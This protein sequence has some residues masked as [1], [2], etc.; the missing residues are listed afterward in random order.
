MFSNRIQ[1][2]H[3]LRVRAAAELELRR[4][5]FNQISALEGK[6][7][8]EAERERRIYYQ[9]HPIDWI[10]D[11]L[12]IRREMIDWELLPQY[13]RH[14]WDG[15]PNPFKV[16]FDSLVKKK[17]VAIEGATGTSKTFYAACAKLWFLENFEDSMV[18]TTAPKK[19]QLELHIWK[20]TSRLYPRFGRGKLM[21]LELRMAPDL[22]GDQGWKAIGFVAGVKAEEVGQSAR[23]AQGFHG[24]DML[25]IVEETPGVAEAVLTALEN[26]SVAPNNLILALGNPD[27]QL[28]ALHKFSQ[29]K[30]VVPITISAF[31]HP[32]VVL[33]D[34]TYMP[35][36]QTEEGLINMLDRL[37]S[38][39]NPMY[40]S[41]ARGISPKQAK[42]ALIR[43]EWILKAVER[44]RKF[45]DE[46]GNIKPESIV[47]MRALGVDVANSEDGDRGAIAR[48]K[49]SVLLEVEEFPCPNANRLGEEVDN[50]IKSLTIAPSYV[51][52]DGIGVGA[53]AVNELKRL[54]S[55][56]LDI[57]SAESP[58]DLYGR[59]EEGKES[60][61]KLV[62]TFDNLRSQ[63]WWQLR[64]D[65][66]DRASDLCLPYD[67][68]LFADLMTPKW[69]TRSGKIVVQP[70]EEI[71]KKLGR[72]PNKGDA[73][74][75]WN[76]VRTLR[77]ISAAASGIRIKDE[78][79]T[80]KK[81]TVK[82]RP[83]YDPKFRQ[84]RRRSF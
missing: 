69:T 57:Q 64:L 12:R 81:S 24:Q 26:T 41:R 75:Y 79:E 56:V 29:L 78:K 36:A 3:A 1:I 38:K 71:R 76:W 74:V 73:A 46:D 6:Q 16:L 15:T 34:P 42:E 35:G 61:L 27:H 54:G 39:D 55:D 5:R 83:R 19:D 77:K 9:T 49:G 72:S 43:Y 17:W 20:E 13:R 11:R 32:N 63:M 33:K 60:G 45:A 68:S 31:D 40:L 52:I 30:R 50:E 58:I 14:R 22:P 2:D 82:T 25:I 65:L 80:E 70:K 8:E 51:G 48:G 18:V 28:D 62:E 53:G 37:K 7:R 47:G 67:E 84:R 10:V 66:E 21:T 44:W 4:R 23:R 59:E